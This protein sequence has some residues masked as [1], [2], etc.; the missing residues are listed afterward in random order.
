LLEVLDPEQNHDFIDHFMEVGIDLSRIFFVTTA[1]VEEKIPPVLH[2]RLEVIRISGYYDSEKM[3]IGRRHLLPKIRVAAGLSEKQLNLSDAVLETLLR[4]YTREAGVRQ[5]FRQLS[6]L[7]RKRARQVVAGKTLAA[8]NPK[9]LQGY[10]GLPLRQERLVPDAYAP[11]MVTALAWTPVGG[12][13]LRIECAL[14][15][16]K[17]RLTLT[18]Q[19]GDVMK[20]SAQIA[21]TLAR[22]RARRF[23]VDPAEFQKTDVHLHVP[24]GSISKDGPSAGVAMLLAMISAMTH[25]A[26]DPRI[27]FTGEISLAGK[28][29]SIGGLPEKAI[30]ALQAGVTRICVPKEN[31]PEVNE[32][33]K[34]AKRG[35]KV[36]SV[37]HV[38][39][40]LT[41]VYG[42]AKTR[43]EKIA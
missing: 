3:A 9:D 25:K 7:A 34:E 42:K 43:S 13:T 11:G 22:I 23:G 17:G 38:D 10:L 41:M 31:A 4:R 40:M 39:E 24:E 28:I 5:L 30:A 21:L 15:S 1:N 26:V 12:E 8:L 27:A 36:L 14:L 19:L 32:L 35:L 18:G 20:E 37:D 29:H 16:G 2:D 6:K 33:P